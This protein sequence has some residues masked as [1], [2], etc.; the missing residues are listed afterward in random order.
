MKYIRYPALLVP[1]EP[2]GFFVRFPD[3]EDTFTAGETEQEALHNAAEVLTALLEW[4]MDNE[5]PIPK[6]SRN[7]AGARYVAPDAQTQAAILL[8]RASQDKPMDEGASTMETSMTGA[9]LQQ[10]E[11]AAATLGKRLL[12]SFV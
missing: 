8:R 3:M 11:Q 9:S 10:L 1:Q 5:Q 6:P 4:R 7:V 12:L 2:K